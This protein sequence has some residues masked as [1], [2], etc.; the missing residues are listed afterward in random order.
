MKSAP[1]LGF[2]G[3]A[4]GTLLLMFSHS[5]M[6]DS[7]RPRELQ[8]SRLLSFTVSWSLLKFMSVESVMLSSHLILCRPLLLW[9][10]IFPSIRG[11]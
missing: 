6:S 3:W 9:P 7:L 11:C 5:V 10:S 2:E 8:R 1:E 4:E